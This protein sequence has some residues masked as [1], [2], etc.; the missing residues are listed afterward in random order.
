MKKYFTLLFS[1]L[2]VSITSYAQVA[3]VWQKCLGTIDDDN[4][5]DASATN[6]GG[7]IIGGTTTFNCTGYTYDYLL[8]K[9]DSLGTQQWVKQFGGSQTDYLSNVIQTNDGGYILAGYTSSNDGD[10]VGAHGSTDGWLVKTD[11]NGNLQWQRACGGSSSDNL[12]CLRNKS[13]GNVVVFGYTSSYNGDLQGIN[14]SVNGALWVLEVDLSGNIVT[15]KCFP[16]SS[17]LWVNDFYI[18]GDGSYIC[19]GHSTGNYGSNDVLTLK[20][21]SSLS[22]IW[23]KVIG[24]SQNDYGNKIHPTSDN[25]YIICSNSNSN[26]FY[27]SGNH[28]T[29][30]N[31]TDYWVVKLDSSRNVLW[32]KC[33]GSTNYEESAD[34]AETADGNFLV[35]GTES[36]NFPDG[37]LADPYGLSQG[38]WAA[39]VD[40][41]GNFLW[42]KVIGG[43]GYEDVS[44]IVRAQDGK[45]VVAGSSNSIDHDVSGNLNLQPGL[46][47]QSD[48]W[49]FKIDDH[50]N[51]ITG[52]VFLDENN[53]SIFDSI[54]FNIP[55]HRIVETS[56]GRI[57]FTNLSGDYSLQVS[58]PGTFTV[59][60]DTLIY[61]NR[62]PSTQSATFTGS[63]EIDSLNDFTCVAAM[64]VNDLRITL[65]SSN[66]IRPGFPAV[67][68]INYK[69]MGTTVMSGQ[70]IFK[71]DNALVY[72]SASVTPDIIAQDSLVWDYQN[73]HPFEERNITVNMTVSTN[74]TLGNIVHTTA[75]ITPY[76]GDGNVDDNVEMVEQLLAGS[77]DPNDITVNIDTLYPSQLANLPYLDYVIRFQN[78][79]NDS[80]I[81]I[82]VANVISPLLDMNT[83]ELIATSHPATV[84]YL[85]HSN[86]LEFFFDNI[87]L[88][89]SN[90]NESASQGFIRYRLK[91]LNTL[92][93]G[94]IINNQAFIYFDYNSA[95]ITNIATTVVTLQTGLNKNETVENDMLIY[96]NPITSTCIIEVKNKT[97]TEYS[98]KIL[99]WTG[100]EIMQM[101][102]NSGKFVVE[103]ES[104]KAGIY[105]AKIKDGNNEFV[106]KLV[107]Y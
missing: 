69:N 42:G 95:V 90:V 58:G 5:L 30:P 70:V 25:G 41:T 73:L 105:F 75:T 26:D 22:L 53:N 40:P 21:D 50:P 2:I 91:P 13:N 88:P 16:N 52:N 66:R 45:L 28:S 3:I 35:V 24:G 34:V 39:C 33:L 77:H 104:L 57:A 6:D 67:Y 101:K 56:S 86:Q 78:T 46:I 85:N 36:T 14:S 71:F 72:G 79:G 9:T 103:K 43:R 64:T 65:T 99:D 55:A 68:Y 81:F 20:I 31:S 27:V 54:D 97:A 7:F 11:S 93:I 10:V 62:V 32:Q 12:N 4:S 49:L 44:T 15:Q 59:Q 17:N 100:R 63:N 29:A 47:Q 8:V 98:L 74:V 37:D 107:A 94:D 23:S 19:V 83:F 60:S 102:N 48:L 76:T 80:A 61:H 38:I 106:K 92:M 82:R 89:D 51:T 18:S 87:Y 96:P 84:T 1:L